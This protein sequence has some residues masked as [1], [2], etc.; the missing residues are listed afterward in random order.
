MPKTTK[1]V[2]QKNNEVLSSKNVSNTKKK[3]NSKAVASKASGIKSKSKVSNF[4]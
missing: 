4:F 1:E 2:N 3:S